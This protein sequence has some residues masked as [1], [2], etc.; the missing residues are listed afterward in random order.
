MQEEWPDSERFGNPWPQWDARGDVTLQ[1]R[2]V[3]F[4]AAV[5]S[6][7]RPLPCLREGRGLATAAGPDPEREHAHSAWP[8][9]ATATAHVC[10]AG[11]G[12]QRLSKHRPRAAASGV[13]S[14]PPRV[15]P[16]S[17]CYNSTLIPWGRRHH[18]LIRETTVNYFQAQSSSPLPVP[19]AAMPR[20]GLRRQPTGDW[21]G[22]TH[23]GGAASV[24]RHIFPPGTC[25]GSFPGSPQVPPHPGLGEPAHHPMLRL[26]SLPK[27]AAG[28]QRCART[29]AN[30][31]P[32]PAQRGCSC[33]SKVG[34]QV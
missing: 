25:C 5:P 34:A 8:P 30:W 9:W 16:R 28:D 32:T 31:A 12:S 26:P 18:H 29:R 27:P 10:P 15:T 22:I 14:E 17:S 24:L 1:S 4:C 6:R 11:S 23:P 21:S 19:A 3:F 33:V 2:R 7:S 13:S 20:R